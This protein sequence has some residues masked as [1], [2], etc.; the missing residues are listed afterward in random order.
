[1]KTIYLDCF[2]GISGN[3]LI[4]AL[5]DAG[6]PQEYLEEQL[7]KLKLPDEYF[8][9][10][11]QT[12]KNGIH[13]V[14]FNVSL[15]NVHITHRT[16][17]DIQKIILQSALSKNVQDTALAIFKN[18][19]EAEAKIH[20]TNIQTVHFH[21]V[22]AIDAIIDIVGA[23]VCLEYLD[24]KD[25]FAG[26]LHTGTGF[27]DCAH[28]RIPIP[29]PATAEL[30]KGFTLKNDSTEKELITPTGA[31]I[32]TTL[33]KE[34]SGLQNFSYDKI[35][36]GA[37]TWELPHPNV[38]RVYIKE[39][40]ENTVVDNLLLLEANIDDMNPQFFSY[41]SEKL[42]KT[43]AL[44]VWITPIMMKKNRPGQMLSVLAKENDYSALCDIVFSETT[45]LGMRVR[46]I[47]RIA[48][49]R[50]IKLV[51]TIYGSVHCKIARYK[52]KISNISAE[53]DDC[54][55]LAAAQN[56][57]LQKIQHEALRIAY[58]LA[59]NKNC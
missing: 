43:G 10:I 47:N 45:T 6:V 7:K 30:L 48:L 18:L 26:N 23:A 12:Q 54:Q 52:G 2:S 27:I 51:S 22:G 11:E 16:L 17:P 24:V 28:G 33:A 57:P 21:E 9:T 31:A 55:K 5:L 32:L 3:M 34:E 37:G 42:F 56:V 4:G 35:A 50:E 59:E 58:Y 38:L 46:K 13:A 19:A 8:L 29:A 20:G 53:Y 39:S 49:D 1:M 25:I 15:G 44:D 41:T 14:Y 40:C 36:Y